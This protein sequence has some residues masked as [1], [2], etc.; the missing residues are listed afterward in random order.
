M[1]GDAEIKDLVQELAQHLSQGGHRLITAE[2]CT[3]GGIS[4]ALTELAGS[5]EWLEGG[6]VTYSNAAKQR[7][8]GV[9][10]GTLAEHGAVSEPTAREM[11][12]GALHNSE[13]DCSLAV[14]G[15]AGP[16]GGSAER[17]VGTVCFAWAAG[18]GGLVAETQHFT[19]DRAGIRQQ[20]IAHALS[21]MLRLMR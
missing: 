5:S 18:D 2:S 4:F 20:A 16:G 7:Q 13:A 15:I 8:L 14:T 11:A 1:I 9:S 17:P 10:A 6:L 19:G 21:G 12:L 3:G